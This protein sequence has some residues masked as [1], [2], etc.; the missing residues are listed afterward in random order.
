MSGTAAFFAYP[1][2]PAEIG[3]TIISAVEKRD[4][5]NPPTIITVWP[6]ISN[7][8]L[9]LDDQIRDRITSAAC[10]IADITVPNFNVFYEIGFAIGRGRPIVPTLNETLRDA[11]KE[12]IQ[13]G[14]FDIIGYLSYSNSDELE[15]KLTALNDTP[16]LHEYAKDVDYQQPLFFLD[17]LAKTDFRNRIVSAIKAARVFYRSY[18]PSEVPRLS[19]TEAIS[20]VTASSGV[21]LP[22]LAPN[23]LDAQRHNLKAAFLAG[24][25]HGLGRKTLLIQLNEEPAAAD[26][27][28]FIDVVRDPRAVTERVMAFA[29]DALS[30]LQEIG[31]ARK[32]R[33]HDLPKIAKLSL[34]ASAAEN[35][36]RHLED[37]FIQTFQFRRAL[38]GSG[39]I[40][41][42][43]KGSGKTA[44]FFQVRDK[45]RED[46]RNLIV[47]LKPESHQLSL[48]RENILRMYNIGV[49]DHTISAFWQHL[50]HI[51]ILLKVREKYVNR[52]VVTPVRT[53]S[54]E[55]S[56]KTLAEIDKVLDS[57]KTD[58]QGDFTSRLAALVRS[59]VLELEALTA[60]G[61]APAVGELTN[62][63]FKVDLRTLRQL[64]EKSI[65]PGTTILFLFDNIDKG[66]SARGVSRDDVRSVRLLVEALNKMQRD[67]SRQGIDFQFLV[68]LRNDIYELLIDETPDRGKEAQIL[69]DW[70]DKEQL[71]RVILERIQYSLDEDFP[72][73]TAAWRTFFTPS[74]QN[75]DSFEHL[76][77]RCLMRPRFLIDLVENCLSIA[78]NRG[79]RTVTEDD[80]ILA[81]RQHSYY[82]I[83]DFG[84]EI[85]D[86][87]AVTHNLF[88]AFIGIGELV[89]YD[90]VSKALGEAG[91][92]ES[93]RAR[94]VDLLLWYGFLGLALASNSKVFIYDVEYDFKRLKALGPG[95]AE[96]VLY[97]IN[98]AFIDGLM[99]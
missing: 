93:E 72:D 34:G 86:V 96:A 60:S 6:K 67:L 24:L 47:D 32:K 73:F 10:L 27:R 29:R 12:L 70:S 44:I 30:E 40:V 1:S 83:S 87:S 63:I 65:Q 57:A 16:L 99:H 55:D 22:L 25:A 77:S 39:K 95:A 26:F 98:P 89:T 92:E 79:H 33:R 50:I 48:L 7:V 31:T 54:K 9:R 62:I 36:F 28:E 42:G 14:L 58:L 64:I 37:Y 2:S 56:F 69:I 19:A 85:R 41:V 35:E 23:V 80:I 81:C 94:V 51:E 15:H 59:I 82:L 76:V 74:V 66:W 4:R 38:D 84:Y 61:K 11:K 3:T 46:R 97:C 13:L 49:F 90:E 5:K 91:I 17:S 68:F 43:R 78:V 45:K 75:V 20:L 8:G 18:D 71:K 53:S 88:Y 21:V 52:P